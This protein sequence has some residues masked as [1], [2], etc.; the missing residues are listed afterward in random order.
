[1]KTLKERQIL[2]IILRRLHWIAWGD[3]DHVIYTLLPSLSFGI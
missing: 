1:M 2:L 3:N